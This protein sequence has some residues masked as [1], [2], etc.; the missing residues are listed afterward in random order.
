MAEVEAITPTLWLLRFPV[1]N[2]YLVRTSDG[3]A[4]VDTGPAGSEDEIVRALAAIDATLAELRHIVLTHSHKDHAGSAASLAAMSGAVVLAGSRD[5]RVIAGDAPEP[6]PRITPEERPFY[7]AV[8]PTIP[9]APPVAVDR[10]LHEGEVLEW[11][12]PAAKV[13]EAPG[14]TPGSIAIYFPD[15]RVLLT[16]D[17]IAS[18]GSQPI[19]GPFN[20][21]RGD[22]IASFHKLTHLDVDI[23]CFGHGAPLVGEASSALRA[24]A[25][26]L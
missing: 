13:V 25:A 11:G 5:A 18:L 4:I 19:L 14:H 24:A 8:A 10:V 2:A 17:N 16:G 21:A 23:A 9:P 20:V 1:V 15:E 6:D 12:A 7:E 3:I 26:R 22:A